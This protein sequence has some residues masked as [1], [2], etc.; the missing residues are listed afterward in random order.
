M[1]ISQDNRQLQLRIDYLRVAIVLVFLALVFKIWLLTV[2][3]YERYAELA[4]RNQIRTIPLTAPRGM[5]VDREGAVL[6]E[7]IHSFNLFLDRE[8]VLN[9]D[10]TR[11]FAIRELGITPSRFDRQ[12]DQASHYP[13]FQPVLLKEDLQ[14]DEIAFLLAHQTEHPEFSIFEQP[15]RL[16]RNDALAAHVLGFV[17]EVSENELDLP[18]YAQLKPGD[19]IGKAGVERVWNAVL[20]GTDGFSRAFVNSHGKILEEVGR[21]PPVIGETL[22]LTLDKELQEVAEAALGDGPGAVVAL[23]P[24]D[25]QILVMA[26]KPSFKPNLF[27]TRISMEDWEELIGNPDHPLQNRAIQSTFSPGSIFKITMALAGLEAGLVDANT[28]VFCSGSVELYGH[29]FHCWNTGGHGHMRLREA[30]Q[31]SC[32]IYFYLL[33]R[34]LG[35]D[36]ISAFS[37]TVGLGEKTG[38]ELS[39]EVAGLVPSKEWKRKAFGQRW[40]DGETISVAIGQG[41]LNVT[42]LQLARSIGIIVSGFRPKLHLLLESGEAGLAPSATPQPRMFREENLRLIRDAMWS[43][44]NEG[45]TGSGARVAGFDVC[46]KTGTAQ[47]ISNRTRERLSEEEQQK[48]VPNAWFVGFAPRDNPEL[49][50]AVIVQRGGS[51]GASAAP[52]AGRLFSAYYEKYKKPEPK[53]QLAAVN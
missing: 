10:R 5:V 32:N 34:K 43:V 39:G 26:S 23:D 31:H 15:R 7:N 51:G 30:I 3:D 1:A 21:T 22:A 8:Q 19:T 45:G 11:R 2:V 20:T 44:V 24:R 41:P 49:V 42:P 36:Q 13:K 6:V 14:M 46:G 52:L 33:G 47:T 50:V 28:R 4:T 16:Y 9:P 17:G 27:A 29:T 38:V 40:Y 35:I 25:G 37:Q 48:Y 18:E 12:L 53:L